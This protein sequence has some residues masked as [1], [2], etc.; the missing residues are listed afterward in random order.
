VAT[1]S[2]PPSPDSTGAG[3]GGAPAGVVADFPAGEDGAGWGPD[4]PAGALPTG[5]LGASE[6]RGL[7]HTNGVRAQKL[8]GAKK[9]SEKATYTK[10]NHSQ[11]P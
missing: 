7:A 6:K 8:N 11:P 5:S 4:P 3:A 9:S 2:E 1:G 10:S